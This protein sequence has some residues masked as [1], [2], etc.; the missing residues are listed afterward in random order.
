MKLNGM[1]IQNPKIDKLESLLGKLVI[2]SKSVN[3]FVFETCF[4]S[5]I[6]CRQMQRHFLIDI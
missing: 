6:I 3:G 1:L 5:L 4:T 2:F